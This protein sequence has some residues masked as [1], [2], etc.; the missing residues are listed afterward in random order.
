MHYRQLGKT[1]ISVSEIGLGTEH[2]AGPPAAVY[3]EV[4]GYAVD[5]G[6]NYVDIL[7]PYPDYRDNIGRSIRGIREKL[8]IAGHIG[9]ALEQGQYLKTRDVKVCR[10]MFEDQL[11]RL[12]TDGVDVVMLQWVDGAAELDEAL[13]PGGTLELAARLKRE[14]KARAVGLSTHEPAT[15]VAA[16]ESGAV[17][18]V[19][20][21]VNLTYSPQ[22]ASTAN[23]VFGVAD[24]ATAK[25]APVPLQRI[26]DVCRRRGVGLVGMKPF[27]GGA[28]FLRRRA[29]VAVTAPSASAVP[30]PATPS[31]APTPAQ[32]LSFSLSHPEVSCALAGVRNLDQLKEDLHY[33]DA[34][35]RERD[36]SAI[37]GSLGAELASG[38]TYCNHCLPC[39]A[40]INVGETLRLLDMVEVLDAAQGGG[41]TLRGD[42][43]SLPVKA[44]ACTACGACSAR[45]PFGVDVA[46]KMARAVQVFES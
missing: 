28:L 6:V 36:F 5:K 29:S 21:P 10:A 22:F 9:I 18:L 46:A 34:T 16:V 4:F 15:A 3:D 41:F 23:A 1:G 11:T 44:S 40:E 39:P 24:P 37:A 12:G 26:L 38:C 14:G 35:A 7:M 43:A 25:R 17:D 27:G 8:V 13:A 2:L 33:L 19:M 30:V 45:C 42:Y 31:P 20:H 32:C